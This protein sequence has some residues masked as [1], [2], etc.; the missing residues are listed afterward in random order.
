MSR[1]SKFR[2]G[3]FATSMVFWEAEIDV[4]N[5]DGKFEE[6]MAM[7]EEEERERERSDRNFVAFSDTL[8]LWMLRISVSVFYLIGTGFAFNSNEGELAME[9]PSTGFDEQFSCGR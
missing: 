6:L 5:R 1:L 3:Q 7:K 4:L 2:D 8:T 9:L